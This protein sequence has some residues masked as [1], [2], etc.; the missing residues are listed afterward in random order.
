MCACQLYIELYTGIKLTTLEAN[1]PLIILRISKRQYQ[2]KLHSVLY[3]NCIL[4]ERRSSNA[5]QQGQC[6][7]ARS[8]FLTFVN[9]INFVR[10]HIDVS[11]SPLTSGW[12]IPNSI[13]RWYVTKH[14]SEDQVFKICQHGQRFK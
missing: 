5:V 4:I 11:A 13:H 6:P 3:Q 12:R 8:H 2:S 1:G 9:K 14:T 7:Y 10:S